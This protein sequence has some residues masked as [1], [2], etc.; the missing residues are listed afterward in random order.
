LP[1]GAYQLLG[2]EHRDGCLIL[3]M[4]RVG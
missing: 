3:T 1:S 4:R 2:R